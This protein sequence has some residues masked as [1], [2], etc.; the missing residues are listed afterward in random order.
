[1]PGEVLPSREFYS[2]EAKYIDGTSGLLIPASLPEET[3]RL[4][5][6]L[7]VQA[8]RAI[9]AAGMARVDFLLD[10]DTGQVFLNELN[11]IPGFTKISMYPKLWGAS[12][13]M[14]LQDRSTSWRCSWRR[15]APAIPTGADS[16]TRTKAPRS[17]SQAQQARRVTNRRS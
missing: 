7:A 2:Y 1:V 5:Q 4:I 14:D 12:G 13:I 11:T 8:Y 17:R 10:K 16:S 15:A 6:E 9:D 3:S